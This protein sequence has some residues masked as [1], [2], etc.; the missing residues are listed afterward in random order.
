MEYLT[1][2]V[3]IPFDPSALQDQLLR[4]YAGPARRAH[5]WVLDEVRANLDSRATEREDGVCDD[6]LTPSLRGHFFTFSGGRW[7]A[8]LMVRYLV[9]PTPRPI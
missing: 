2:A 6:D 3:V 8:A 4:S 5:N 7:Q 1:R 9:A